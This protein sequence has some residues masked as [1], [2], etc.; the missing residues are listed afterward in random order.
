MQ[1][2]QYVIGTT[3]VQP[4]LTNVYYE[5]AD[6]TVWQ[7]WLE[8]AAK[9]QVFPEDK[10]MNIIQ[11]VAF[12]YEVKGQAMRT[13]SYM[14]VTF[15]DGTLYMKQIQ[16]PNKIQDVDLYNESENDLIIRRAGMDGWCLMGDTHDLL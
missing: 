15:K 14:L 6:L 2:A 16:P 12:Y 8:G 5:Q 13:D 10:S 1:T 11:V 7:K 4:E 9:P 3:R